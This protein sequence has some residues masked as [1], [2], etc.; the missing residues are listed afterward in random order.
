MRQSPVTLSKR[1]EVWAYINSGHVEVYWRAPLGETRSVKLLK[2]E[3]RKL[4]EFCK[5]RKP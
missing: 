3:V 1:R 4:A 2:S 5:P